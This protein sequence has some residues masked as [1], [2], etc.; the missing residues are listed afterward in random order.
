MQSDT[1]P[2]KRQA[3]PERPKAQPRQTPPST[4]MQPDDAGTPASGQESDAPG[5]AG[6]PPLKQ[7]PH[8]KT[9]PRSGRR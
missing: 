5:T 7:A 3:P 1:P 2:G 9:D 6:G 8:D 4:D